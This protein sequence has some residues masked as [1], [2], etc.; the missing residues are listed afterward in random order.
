MV[1]ASI[2]SGFNQMMDVTLDETTATICGYTE[3]ELKE[4]FAPFAEPLAQASHMT[5]ENTW[6]LLRDRYN[7]Y[8]WGKG[9]RVYNPWAILNC[10]RTREF[11]NYWWDS[12]TP[13]I[14]VKLAHTLKEPED[15]DHI[16]ATEMMLLF[17]LENIKS[18]PLL[19]QT[20]YLTIKEARRRSYVLGFPNAEVRE[21]WN[22][23]LLD[24][25]CSQKENLLGQSTAAILLE[26]L[27]TGMHAQFEKSL[28]TLFAAIP[29][30]LHLPKESFY[31][32]VFVAALQAVGGRLIAELST[33]KGRVDAVL[34]TPDY[35]Y[36]IE[37]KL[38]SA[39]EAL[40]QIQDKRY[41]EQYLSDSRKIVLLG[42]GGFAEKNIQCLWENVK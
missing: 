14:L 30:Q 25:F 7:G 9:D 20:G 3:N 19:W 31:H 24:R 10:M 27:E 36:I 22:C 26:A 32:A 37:F 33:D 11:L 35:I 1:K 5:V 18:E 39:S 8:W 13:S 12:G 34:K 4:Y 41:C 21:A 28:N 29:Y 17:D 15:M 40:A 38:G 6:E 42:A 2:F 16:E 23:M